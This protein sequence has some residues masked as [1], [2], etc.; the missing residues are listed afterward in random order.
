MMKDSDEIEPFPGEEDIHVLLRASDKA[1]K[2]H[3]SN[4]SRHYTSNRISDIIKQMTVLY[5]DYP[6]QTSKTIDNLY[7]FIY[8]HWRRSGVLT[9]LEEMGID[10]SEES[11][12]NPESDIYNII[13]RFIVRN[14]LSI[15]R[16]LEFKSKQFIEH[17]LPF[18]Y[19]S[20]FH[21]PK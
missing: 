19:S 10:T 21:F 15:Q 1:T 4:E 7:Q 3:L 20:T 11:A 18:L 8:K 6:L 16:V 12:N 13:C 5:Y 14:I 9:A 2:I 17:Y